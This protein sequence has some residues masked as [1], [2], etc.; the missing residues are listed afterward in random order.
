MI[1]P[2]RTSRLSVFAALALLVPAPTIGVFAAMWAMPGPA[3]QAIYGLSK[4]WIIALPALW[5]TFMERRRPAVSR[6]PMGSLIVGLA[7]GAAIGVAILTGYWLIGRAWIDAEAVRAVAAKNGLDVPW[8]YLALSIY[9]TLINSL[10][11]EYVWRWFVFTKCEALLQSRWLA[12]IASGLLFTLH[13][14]IALGLQ[15]DDAALTAL[16]SLGVFVGGV[17]WSWLYLRYRSVW[18]GYA[19]HI[20]AD[21]AVFLVGWS[22]LFG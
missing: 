20:L 16:A 13:H 8:R 11:E 1:E 4:A 3:G 10:V 5:L 22:I 18:P 9:L 21:V 19:S 14:A 15:F 6:P 2:D 7:T 12:A 17:T